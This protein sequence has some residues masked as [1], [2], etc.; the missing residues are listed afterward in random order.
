MRPTLSFHLSANADQLE[1]RIM[2]ETEGG[3]KAVEARASRD[4]RMIPL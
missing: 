2:P 4:R 3:I 1:A